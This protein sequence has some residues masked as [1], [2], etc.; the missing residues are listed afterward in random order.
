[1]MVLLT[2]PRRRQR[3]PSNLQKSRSSVQTSFFSVQRSLFSVQRSLIAD[4]R[5]ALNDQ[6]AGTRTRVIATAGITETLRTAFSA[7]RRVGP[8]VQITFRDDPAK[9]AAWASAKHLERAPKENAA[10]ADEAAH[11][12]PAKAMRSVH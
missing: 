5:D 1:M 12:Q 8:I 7:V 3:P 11:L 10:A 2:S 4:V 9:L 6:T